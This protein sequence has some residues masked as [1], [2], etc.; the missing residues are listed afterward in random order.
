VNLKLRTG[1]VD[2]IDQVSHYSARPR[3]RS[4]LS[5]ALLV[6]NN[7]GNSF[8]SPTVAEE[9]PAESAEPILEGPQPPSSQEG[10]CKSGQTGQEKCCNL[11]AS[12]VA[13]QGS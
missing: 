9:C 4:D 6:Y 2:G 8:L 11:S 13:L 1:L 12:W 10:K 5:E 7:Q 3:P